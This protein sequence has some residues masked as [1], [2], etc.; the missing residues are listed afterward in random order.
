M[1]FLPLLPCEFLLLQVSSHV[2]SSG[3]LSLTPWLGRISH[4]SSC[5]HCHGSC[6]LLPSTSP[7]VE[8]TM[9]TSS[10][11]P[12][13]HMS[14]FTMGNI[15]VPVHDPLHVL[16][17]Q[18]QSPFSS[19][20]LQHPAPPPQGSILWPH[21]FLGSPSS[22]MNSGLPFSDHILL[23]FWQESSFPHFYYTC[24]SMSPKLPVTKLP[25][26]LPLHLSASP[27]LSSLLRFKWWNP[28]LQPFSRHI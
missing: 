21:H 14:A 28:S 1:L 22:D 12:F 10:W 19:T 7:A 8:M 24:F 25:Y 17:F 3:K 4:W 15:K 18:V 27:G 5:C 13:P 26:A 6:R 20:P 23:P 2:P 9:A 11:L 16:V